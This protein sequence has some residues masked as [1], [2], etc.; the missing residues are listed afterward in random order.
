VLRNA[1]RTRPPT[2][3]SDRD[4]ALIAFYISAGARAR[5]SE[6]LGVTR[7]LLAPEDQ[8]IGVI[9]KGSRALQQ[10]PA[11]TDAFAWLKLYQLEIRDSVPAGPDDD[12]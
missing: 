2:R 4:R 1:L 11:S 3:P 12:L 8:L 7:R 6:P 10:L 5:A 9:R